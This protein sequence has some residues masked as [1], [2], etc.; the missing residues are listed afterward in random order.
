MQICRLA[1][2]AVAVL[3]GGAPARALCTIPESPC[4]PWRIDKGSDSTVILEILPNNVVT[5]ANYRL[6][7]CAPA[8]GVQLSMDFEDKKVEIGKVELNSGELVAAITVSCLRAS[9]G[10][11]CIASA[12]TRTPA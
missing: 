12:I 3:A 10:S 8:N 7:V 1:V 4:Y 6:C 2:L 5:S 9:R 11:H